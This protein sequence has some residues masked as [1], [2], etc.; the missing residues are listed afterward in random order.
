MAFLLTAI[1]V[2]I[3]LTTFSFLIGLIPLV[4]LDRVKRFKQRFIQL[5]I[6]ILLSTIFIIIVPEGLSVL[7]EDDKKNVGIYIILGFISV[8][9]I[10][11][12]IHTF[13]AR[14]GP[15]S[16][17][18]PTALSSYYQLGNFKMTWRLMLN[19]KVTFPLFIHG[20]SDGLTLGFIAISDNK[21]ISTVIILATLIHKIPALISLVMILVLQQ[22]LNNFDTIANLWWFALSTPLG[23]LVTAIVLKLSRVSGDE[24]T[25]KFLIGSAG[26]LIFALIQTFQDHSQNHPPASADTFTGFDV[27]DGYDLDM[28]EEDIGHDSRG[29]KILMFLTGCFI[30]WTISLLIHE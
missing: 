11:E 3:S 30:P 13:T 4:F 28:D 25:G 8:Y 12:Y 10:E 14:G 16:M 23:Y 22:N 29:I 26:S 1:L 20:L 17:G 9:I 27:T 2:F 7:A 19:N 6:G 5:S 15:G 18:L 21:K 24:I